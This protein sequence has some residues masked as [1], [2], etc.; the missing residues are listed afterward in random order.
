[1]K[2]NTKR[3]PFSLFFGKLHRKLIEVKSILDS[4]FLTAEFKVKESIGNLQLVIQSSKI[5]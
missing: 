1:M 4:N 3:V 5:Q 2:Y